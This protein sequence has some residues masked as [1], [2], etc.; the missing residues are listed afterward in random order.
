MPSDTIFALS[1]GRPPAGVAVVRLSGPDA[2][3]ALSYLAGRAVPP[4]VATLA[5]LKDSAG[6]LLDRAI[7]LAFPAPAS[8]TGE[9][10]VELHLHG[11]AAVVSA[12]LAELETLGLRLAAPGEFSRRAFDNGKLDLTQAE[13]IADLIAAETEAQRR[14][15]LVQ[16]GGRLRDCAEGW[17]LRLLALRAEVEAELDFA[18]EDDVDAD[19][20][21][22]P[23]LARLVAEISA[24]LDDKQIGERLRE[25]F[26]IAVIG[27]P[28]AGKSSLIN[29]IARRDVAIVTPVAGT[30]RDVL[31][32][33]LSIEGVPV[34]LLDTAGLRESADRIEAEGIRRAR[35]RA[36]EAD[37]VLHVVEAGGEQ[38][39]NLGDTCLVVVSK[40]DLIAEPFPV[41]KGDFLVSS[42]TGQGLSDLLRALKDWATSQASRGESS[43]ITQ[44]RHRESLTTCAN[45]LTAAS[46]SADVVVRAEHL[47]QATGALGRI[48][49]R[50]GVEEMLDALFGRFCIGK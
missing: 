49:G 4:R 15:A 41:L 44:T 46:K 37:L 1:S 26:T 25:G 42:K 3:A 29:A 8:F 40:A 23:D 50:A 38:A 28:N 34:M 43:L 5:T 48:T 47:R 33:P 30:T 39:S 21:P 24:A 45:Y 7:V 18:D 17:R 2:L 10:V 14:Q 6:G 20:A 36:A 32:V 22:S 11:G 31:E 9:D 35:A 27:S 19:R 13:G 16:A 12:M